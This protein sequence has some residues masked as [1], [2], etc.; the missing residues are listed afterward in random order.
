MKVGAQVTGA[1]DAR[2]N[3]DSERPAHELPNK[4]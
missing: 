3:C 4:F 2:A 1:D